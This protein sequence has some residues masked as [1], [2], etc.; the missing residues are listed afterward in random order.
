MNRICIT[1]MWHEPWSRVC[2]TAYIDTQEPKQYDSSW[3]GTMRYFNI[4]ILGT[5]QS[6]YY[7]EFLIRRPFVCRPQMPNPEPEPEHFQILIIKWTRKYINVALNMRKSKLKGTGSGYI[8]QSYVQT[9][10]C[11]P[12]GEFN[13]NVMNVIYTQVYLKKHCRKS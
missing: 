13:I 11:H 7:F 12:S 10:K 4:T 3:L 1:I 6:E 9:V 5:T 2:Q 8:K